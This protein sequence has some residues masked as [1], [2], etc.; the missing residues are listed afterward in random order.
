MDKK[1][2]IGIYGGTFDPIHNGHVRAALAFLEQSDVDIL[3]IMPAAIPPHKELVS[4]VSAESRLRMCELAFCDHGEFGK[5]IIVSDYEVKQGGAS[6]TVLTLRHF[7][8]YADEI[9]FLCGTDMFL[10][11][12]TWYE[13]PEIFRRAKI[14]YVRRES[15]VSLDAKIEAKLKEYKEKY[16]ASIKC[17]EIAPTEL[18][19]KDVRDIFEHKKNGGELVPP[20]VLEYIK[21]NRLYE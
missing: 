14:A 10:S 4:H 9:E 19:S 20:R 6:Y 1:K 11:L 8:K 13:A 18:A 15:D 5:R 16:G 12:D 21:E 2:K 7:E 17:I 3:Y